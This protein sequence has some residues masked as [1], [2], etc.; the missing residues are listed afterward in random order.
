VSLRQPETLSLSARV[1]GCQ[2]ASA[3]E[4]AASTASHRHGPSD[5]QWPGQPLSLRLPAR[6]AVLRSA[7]AASGCDSK[8]ETAPTGSGLPES[9]PDCLA[10]AKYQEGQPRA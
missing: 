6:L 5:C 7:S 4:S 10:A 3:S 1:S 2:A 8:S 9:G